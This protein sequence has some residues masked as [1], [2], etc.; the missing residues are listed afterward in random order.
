MIANTNE[1]VYTNKRFIQ[2]DFGSFMPGEVPARLANHFASSALDELD[3]DGEPLF[4]PEQCALQGQIELDL[5]LEMELY[6]FVDNLRAVTE[7]LN[8]P[9]PEPLPAGKHGKE[10]EDQN[11]ELDSTFISHWD[12]KGDHHTLDHTL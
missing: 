2:H 6:E 3:S 10:E 8:V 7:R 12:E 5:D 4:P 1:I 9:A 11:F